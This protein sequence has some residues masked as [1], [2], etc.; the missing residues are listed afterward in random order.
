MERVPRLSDAQLASL[1]VPVQV[2]V[3]SADIML[4]SAETR[5]RFERCVPGAHVH[6]LEGAGHLL[7]PQTSTVSEFFAAVLAGEAS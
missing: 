2:I 5:G 6:Y 3:G 7:P 1:A 4:R